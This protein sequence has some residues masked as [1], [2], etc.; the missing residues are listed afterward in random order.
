MMEP[1]EEPICEWCNKPVTLFGELC[2][3]CLKAREDADN[4]IGAD[5]DDE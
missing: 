2:E 4:G 3:D 1:D 5:W